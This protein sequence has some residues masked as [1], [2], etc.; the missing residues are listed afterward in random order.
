[1]RYIGLL[2][3]V[4]GSDTKLIRP[5]P[6]PRT[7]PL[8]LQGAMVRSRDFWKLNNREEEISGYTSRDNRDLLDKKKLE[9]FTKI[10]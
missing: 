3:M 1:M 10:F 6:Q 9:F 5:L 7:T 2:D 8:F 4:V